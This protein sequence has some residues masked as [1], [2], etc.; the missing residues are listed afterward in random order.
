VPIFVP[1]A[2]LSVTWAPAA[3]KICARAVASSSRLTVAEIVIAE[4]TWDT[5]SVG[6]VYPAEAAP[7]S[8]STEAVQ[9]PSTASLVLLLI[10]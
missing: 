5:F 10:R 6:V 4:P 9:T 2:W 8:T 1:G 3:A 7:A